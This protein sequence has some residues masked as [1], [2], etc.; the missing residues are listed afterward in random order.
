MLCEQLGLFA[1]SAPTADDFSPHG[2]AQSPR[3]S[4][5]Q[6]ES[7]NND[8]SLSPIAVSLSPHETAANDRDEMDALRDENAAMKSQLSAIHELLRGQLRQMAD[9]TAEL[10][11]EQSAA[12]LSSS[13]GWLAVGAGCSALAGAAV[14]LGAR[15]WQG[16]SGSGSG[17]GSGCPAATAAS[18]GDF[19]RTPV[20]GQRW[21]SISFE[22]AGVHRHVQQ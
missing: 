17:S 9:A 1:S 8:V 20:G 18:G 11:G 22:L 21:D 4:S 10:G 19:L 5:P 6:T 12:A 7:D 2:A 15:S 13:L 16:G 3:S 14:Y